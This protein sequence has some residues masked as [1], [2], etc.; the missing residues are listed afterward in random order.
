MTKHAVA[1]PSGAAKW[2]GCPGSLAMEQGIPNVGSKYSDAGTAAH[3]LSVLLR[4][5][6]CIAVERA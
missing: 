6:R 3:F 5:K 2:M 1:S 4:W